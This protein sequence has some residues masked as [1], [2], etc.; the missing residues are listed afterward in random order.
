[1]AHLMRKGISCLGSDV[2]GAIARYASN[3]SGRKLI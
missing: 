1:M 2:P 3:G